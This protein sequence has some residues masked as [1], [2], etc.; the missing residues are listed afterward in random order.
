MHFEGWG[1]KPSNGATK[2]AYWEVC[3][4]KYEHWQKKQLYRLGSAFERSINEIKRA[5]SRFVLAV[6]A[7]ISVVVPLPA[8]FREALH[9]RY[10][11]S[12]H[13]VSSSLLIKSPELR[14]K[15]VKL[16]FHPDK[17]SPHELSAWFIKADKDKPTVVFSH[18]RD[19]NISHLEHIIKALNKKGYG[20]FVYDYPGFGR[21]EGRPT[22]QALYEA[23][24]A[25][26]KFLT[27][28]EG[29]LNIPIEQQII[30]GHSLGGAIAVDVAKKLS[31]SNSRP[32]ALVLV[33]TF[34]DIKT[35]FADQQKRYWNPVQKVFK[36]DKIPF[37][38]NSQEKIKSV[39]CP[40]L[41]FHAEQDKV[42]NQSHG[43]ALIDTFSKVQD[44]DK[45]N[46]TLRH[47][48]VSIKAAGHR[49][50]AEA[51]ETIVDKLDNFIQDAGAQA[52]KHLA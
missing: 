38:F 1:K 52:L 30:M 22:E 10:F 36:I 25:A 44:G 47:E 39:K 26:S 20:I 34:T 23:G 28:K 14:Q 11:F 21:S 40:V 41:G 6:A 18:G 16:G 12:P 49:M 48:F 50:T 13:K 51:C 27:Q 33:N 19:C 9:R 5:F 17:D 15:L 8:S 31:D 3:W 4:E 7:I 2:P 37:N 42:I 35:A 43:K 45:T 46:P 29:I 24:L 32:K